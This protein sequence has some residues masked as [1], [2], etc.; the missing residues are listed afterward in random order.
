MVNDAV[1]KTK[2]SCGTYSSAQCTPYRVCLVV[3]WIAIISFK[4]EPSCILQEMHKESSASVHRVAVEVIVLTL[5]LLSVSAVWVRGTM[6]CTTHPM[7]ELVHSVLVSVLS[8]T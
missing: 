5:F 1:Q 8:A 7:V 6:D 3:A 4:D 2:I